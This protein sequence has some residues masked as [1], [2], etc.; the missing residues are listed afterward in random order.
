MFVL[1]PV[2]DCMNCAALKALSCDF[3]SLYLVG[4]APWRGIYGPQG[5]PLSALAET[6]KQFSKMVV[7]IHTSISQVGEVFLPLSCQP[8]V[9]SVFWKFSHFDGRIV[10][11]HYD[12]NLIYLMVIL[13]H[14]FFPTFNHCWNFFKCLSILFHFLLLFTALKFC[15]FQMGE[16]LTFFLK[17]T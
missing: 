2:W 4:Y 15:I 12:F 6:A 13:F 5:L 14:Y 3:W 9:F 8:L 17:F 10:V 7:L 1:F 11:V 16:K